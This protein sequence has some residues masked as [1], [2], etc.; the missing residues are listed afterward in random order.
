MGSM[1]FKWL[2]GLWAYG[3][4]RLYRVIQRVDGVYQVW[5]VIEFKGLIGC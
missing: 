5:G 4:C 2:K 1:G 3:V